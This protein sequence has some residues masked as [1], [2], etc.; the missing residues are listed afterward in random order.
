MQP[1]KP[2]RVLPPGPVHRHL[3]RLCAEADFFFA[4][5]IRGSILIVVSWC[6]QSCSGDYPQF[7]HRPWR[8]S[9]SG[10]DRLLLPDAQLGVPLLEISA[11]SCAIV[12][13]VKMLWFMLGVI[14][15]ALF[16]PPQN[17]RGGP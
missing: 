12:S 17:K 1:K 13:D 14:Y 2:P 16:F 7:F 3:A 8:I 6:R 11:P 10:G 15:T 9:L 5:F 4:D